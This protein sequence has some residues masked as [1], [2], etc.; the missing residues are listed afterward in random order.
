M[1]LRRR[2]GVPRRARQ[3]RARPG[4]IESPSLERM[5]RL[6]AAMGDPQLTL[7]GDPRHRHERQGLDGADDHPP[8]DGPRPDGRHVHQPAPR[9]DQ[10]AHQ[11]QRRAD[12]R[13]RLRRAD[14]RASPTSRC[15][16][17]CARR[18]S[19]S[20]PRPP[21]AGSPTS[22]STWRWSRSACSAAGTPPT[23][24]TPRS[25]SITNIGLDHTEFAGPTLARHRPREGRASSSPAARVVRRRDRPGA[26]RRLPAE[27]AASDAACAARTSTS[28]DNQLALGGRLVDLRTPTTIYPE[29]F[30]PLHGAHQ[31][32]NA[33]VALTAVE[34]FFAAPLRRGRRREGFADGRDAG[35]L[36]GDRPPAAG[37]HRRRPQPGRR[38]RRA[39]R[40]SSTTSIPPAGGSW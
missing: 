30:V 26:G 8:A 5:Q 33:A 12:H 9:A 13:R 25:P 1:D 35:P 6:V 29:V 21:S 40:C 16:P 2:A 15:S 7:P 23:S 11:P 20:S 17:A 39:P 27:P 22:P 19:R 3:L 34:A 4:A 38:R 10:R 32:D 14:R 28:L 37:D 36:R 31:G 18:T 24:S